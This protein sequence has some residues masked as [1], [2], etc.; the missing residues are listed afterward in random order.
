[1]ENAL[2]LESVDRQIAAL[3]ARRMQASAA[4][5]PPPT[6]AARAALIRDAVPEDMREYAYSLFSLL[7]D[8]CRAEPAGG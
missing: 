3:F 8:L 2:P 4:G 1:M 6:A 7:D 5:A